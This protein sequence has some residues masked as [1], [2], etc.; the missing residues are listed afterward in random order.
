MAD[1]NG[2]NIAKGKL[3]A[4][5]L[6]ASDTISGIVIGS[7]AAPSLALNTPRVVYNLKDVEKLG[8]TPQFDIDNKV[9][10]F[11]HLSEF[12]RNAG[13]GIELYLM[14]VAQTTTISTIC[15]VDARPLLL[16]AK[17]KIRQLA[18]AINVTEATSPVMLDGLPTDVQNGIPKAQGLANWAFDNKMPCQVFLEGYAYGGDASTVS[19]LREIVNVKATKVSVFIGQDYGYAKNQSIKNRKKYADVGTLLGICSKAKVNQNVGN[20]EEFDI[21]D[22]TKGSWLEPGLSSHQK[23][24]D[25]YHDL[26]TLEDKAFL[27]GVEYTGLAGVRINNDHTCVEI[28]QDSDNSTNEHSIAYGRTKDKAIRGLRNVYLPKVKTDWPIDPKT[29]K[30]PPGVVVALEDLGDEVFENMVKRGELSYGKTIVDK[31][32]DLLIDKVLK[33]SFEIVPKGSIGEVSGTINL[34]TSI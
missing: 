8:I 10:V 13:E 27:F 5:L 30:L 25:V 23:N 26:Q 2:V 17:G 15:D 18:I 28:I 12:Y 9:H 33:V 4:N 7:V 3:G 29:G 20:N 1:L 32:S 6:G 24:T 19:N 34:K 11:R 22:A 21:T 14:L 16:F 31:D